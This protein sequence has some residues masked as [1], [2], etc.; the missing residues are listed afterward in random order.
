MKVRTYIRSEGCLG[1]TFSWVALLD[2]ETGNHA[3]ILW[4]EFRDPLTDF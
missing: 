4:T 3:A 1:S 2:D